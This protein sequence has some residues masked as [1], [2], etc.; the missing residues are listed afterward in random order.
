MKTI[1]FEEYLKDLHSKHYMGTDDDMPIAF[2][3]FLENLTVSDWLEYGEIWG[4]INK[5]VGHL[6]IVKILSNNK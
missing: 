2:E 1:T 3:R 6:E 5:G 4:Q